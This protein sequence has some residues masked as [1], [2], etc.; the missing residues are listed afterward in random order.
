MHQALWDIS[1]DPQKVVKTYS[2]DHACF[3]DILNQ[4]DG[5][6]YLAY[7]IYTICSLLKNIADIGAMYG[8]VR[9][10][11]IMIKL[12]LAKTKIESIKFL[13][14]GHIVQIEEADSILIPEQIEHLPPAMLSY[15][16]NIKR[17]QN[18]NDHEG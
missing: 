8:N 15:L 13:S 11:N 3:F 14:F 17:F 10:E 18:A 7:L 6:K 12:D 5:R 9:T 4:Q 16:M 2:L 1:F